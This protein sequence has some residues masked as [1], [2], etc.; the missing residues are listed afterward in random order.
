AFRDP[1]RRVVVVELPSG[2]EIRTL[3]PPPG[4][5]KV[6]PWPIALGGGRVI[7]MGEDLSVWDL[8]TGKQ[9]SSWSLLDANLLVK[10]GGGRRWQEPEAVAVSPDGKQ[11]AF[12][13]VTGLAQAAT[14]NAGQ[15]RVFETSGRLLRTIEVDGNAPRRLAFSPDGRL[16]AGGV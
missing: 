10:Q 6:S 12:S 14:R 4:K 1:Q 2:K 15:I 7:L 11:V 3:S 13:V 16:L 8:T 5:E 9:L